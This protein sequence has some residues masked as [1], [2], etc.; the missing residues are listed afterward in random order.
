M[1]I[2]KKLAILQSILIA[3]FLLSC[4][5]GE[6]QPEQDT[7]SG[8]PNSQLLVSSAELNEQL[9]EEIVLLIDARAEQPDSLIPGAIWFA[10]V[11]ELTDPDHPVDNYLVGPVT[12][13]QKM[14]AIGLDADDKVI[15]Y[16][17]GNSLAAARLFYAL[18]NYGFDNAALLNGG[19]AAW[20]ENGYPI[21]TSPAEPEAGSFTIAEEH[22]NVYCDFSYVTAASEDPD[23]IIFDVRS[24]EEYSGELK[25][26]DKAGHIPNAVNLEWRNVLEDEGVPYFLPAD[27]IASQYEEMGITP[28]KEVIPHCQSNVRG[29]HAYFT[30]RLMGYDSVRPYEGS[31]AEYGNREDSVV[32]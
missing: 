17:E 28:D 24:P 5:S 29:S 10:A 30:L 3:L 8:Y 2:M 20:I 25:R 4:S 14:R 13:Q 6:V 15:I 18:E 21:A 7:E 9:E 12:F 16:D 32:Q 31:W 23:K 26:A 22:Q 19:F 11:P 27:E 1:I